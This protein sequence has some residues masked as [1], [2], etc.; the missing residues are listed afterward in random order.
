MSYMVQES[1]IR[2]REEFYNYLHQNYNLKD[3]IF[4]K[5]D[6][7]NSPF[8]FVI[9]NKSLWVCNSITTCACASRAGRIISIKEFK[10]RKK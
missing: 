10:E 4:T 8:P 5:E 7:I 3:Y 9:S 2:K 1:D 6:M